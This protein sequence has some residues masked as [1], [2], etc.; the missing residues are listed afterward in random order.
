MDRFRSPRKIRLSGCRRVPKSISIF[1]S[2]AITAATAS[3]ITC[4]TPSMPMKNAKSQ[5]LSLRSNLK[6][7][8]RK[9]RLREWSESSLA[10]GI[11]VSGRWRSLVRSLCAIDGRSIRSVARSACLS[12]LP[13]S[14]KI[15]IL[16]LRWQIGRRLICRCYRNTPRGANSCVRHCE[17]AIIRIVS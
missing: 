11:N 4:C 7:K 8:A 3:T 6:H 1:E 12:A 9:N 10:T 15:W 14:L 16:I 5:R 17:H 2:A 13:H